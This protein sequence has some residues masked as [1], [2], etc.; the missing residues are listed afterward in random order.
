M[1]TALRGTDSKP[2]KG[3]TTTL[4]AVILRFSTLS[5][6]NPQIF[7]LKG[8]TS[9]PVILI[10]KFPPPPT[11]QGEYMYLLQYLRGL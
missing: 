4:P 10:G 5:G 2:L 1:L 8:M 11:S 3:T 7:P 6:T 9:N